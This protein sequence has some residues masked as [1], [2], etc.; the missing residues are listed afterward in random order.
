[1]KIGIIGGTGKMG[2]FFREVFEN[3]GWVVHVSGRS[4]GLRAADIARVCDVVMVSVPIRETVGMIRSIAPLLSEEQVF[5]D[6]TSLK[7]EPVEAMLAS[8]ARVVGLHPMFG[9]SAGGLSG[10]TIIATPARC[11]PATLES[12]LSVFRS[13]GA[14]VTLAT[15]V[16]HDRIMAV[17]QGLT[18]FVT[19]GVAE[20]MR[21]VGMSP[22]DTLAFMSPVYQ[23]E[24]GLVGRLLSQ[25]PQLYADILELNPHVPPVLEACEEALSLLRRI[26]E[27]GDTG[28]FE[29]VFRENSKNFGEYCQRAARESDMLISA[30]VRE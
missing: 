26:V 16:E 9:P 24:M 18:H 10:Q 20:T 5:C 15:P 4:T 3:A 6:L 28:A 22:A 11:D 25:D 19:L 8:R 1:M 21:R 17:V 14:R 29:E 13:Q 12:L 27:A 7:S 23:M 30:M 2:A